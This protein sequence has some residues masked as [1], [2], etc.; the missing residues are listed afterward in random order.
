M[1][2]TER[3]K[4]ATEKIVL[5]ARAPEKFLETRQ[6]YLGPFLEIS[7]PGSWVSEPLSD[8]FSEYKDHIWLWRKEMLE[9]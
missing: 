2:L 8:F 4:A 1:F 7:D 5:D 3:K 6:R 9:S